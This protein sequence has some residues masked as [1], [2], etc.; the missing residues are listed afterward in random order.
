MYSFTSID[1]PLSTSVSSSLHSPQLALVP[2]S[3]PVIFSNFS[4][5]PSTTI[6]FTF[7]PIPGMAWEYLIFSMKVTHPYTRSIPT[8]WGYSG[9]LLSIIFRRTG[10]SYIL[11]IPKFSLI[12]P[13]TPTPYS[14][15][16]SHPWLDVWMFSSPL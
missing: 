1:T 9:P 7:F 4:K 14:F 8:T 2:S 13:L 5:N 16:T 10:I 15:Q 11:K 3:P 6:I 12:L